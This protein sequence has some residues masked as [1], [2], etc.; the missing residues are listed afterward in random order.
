MGLS[1]KGLVMGQRMNN[2]GLLKAGEIYRLGAQAKREA[3]R[4]KDYSRML[5]I[6]IE[7]NRSAICSVEARA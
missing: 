3:V 1:F 7:I 2:H 4:G 6:E 5:P